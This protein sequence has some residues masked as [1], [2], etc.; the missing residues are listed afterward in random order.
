MKY[1]DGG[2]P[3]VNVRLV[4]EGRIGGEEKVVMPMQAVKLIG[5]EI[6]DLARKAVYVINLDIRGRVL[7]IHLAGLGMTTGTYISGKEIFLPALLA[8]AASII[9]VHNH[10]GQDPTPSQTDKEL[11]LM[12][13]DIGEMLG[14]RVDDHI[15]ISGGDSDNYYSFTNERLLKKE[16]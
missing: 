9:I 5:H 12:M 3:I 6:S 4:N 2:V 7:S 11:T 13:S 15:I 8:N 16:I 10:P 14:I 1:Y